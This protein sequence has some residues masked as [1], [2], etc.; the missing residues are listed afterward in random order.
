MRFAWRDILLGSGLFV[1]VVLVF[2]RATESRFINI[3]D[4][5]YVVQNPHVTHGVNVQDLRWDWGLSFY[6]SNWHPLTWLSLQLDTQ[7]FG[8]ASY[9]FHRTNV[10]LHAAN[11]VLVFLVLRIMTR[12]FWPS[13]LVAAV[14]ALHPLRVESVAWVAERKDVLSVF[15]GLLTIL[16][17]AGY[18]RHADWSRRRLVSLAW[19]GLVTLLF[20]LGLLAKPM[21]VTLPCV[22]LL[23][24]YWPLGR[25]TVAG[26]DDGQSLVAKRLGLLVLEKVPWLLLS[27]VDSIMNILA[28]QS[29]GSILSL[30][31]LSVPLRLG[32]AVRGYG[33]YLLKTIW[34]I[35][36]AAHYPHPGEHL[37][38]SQV[39]VAAVVLVGVTALVVWQWRRRPY[40]LVGWLWFA[41]VLFPVSGVM[42]T[43]LQGY[44]DRFTYFP[45][46]GLLLAAVWLLA[47]W[48]Q[49]R[50]LSVPI[51]AGAVG[52]VLVACTVL[53]FGQIGYW[54]DSLT[55]WSHCL[56]VT[57]PSAVAENHIGS[58][59]YVDA[60]RPDLA[61]PHLQAA[62]QLDPD[63]AMNHYDLALALVAL[64]RP[65]TLD[66]AAEHCQIARQ[67]VPRQPRYTKLLA[68]IEMEQGRECLRD[69]RS[70]QAKEHL[71]QAVKLDPEL[72]K[73]RY[74]LG[75]ALL[76]L[77]D[78]AGAAQQLR[79]AKER[80]MPQAE[81]DGPLK[82]AL[83]Q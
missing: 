72:A 19:Y 18:V 13:A 28:Q 56:D 64:H 29:Y 47:E 10:L 78:R 57:G 75:L 69:G 37:V 53:T 25:M 32:N 58:A 74:H 14:F 54:H 76:S 36:L 3:D 27:V 38:W 1:L 33:M 21:L 15:F 42:Q 80:G 12:A 24:D 55:L 6:A 4:F 5:T 82:Q 20:T 31:H 46:I 16:A 41:G 8:V 34:P 9:A 23:L 30:G 61:L 70:N 39:V 68:F 66:I 22:L 83:M 50:R 79:E 40:L 65:G 35:D 26:T 62:V 43:G 48:A 2:W 63:D 51:Q 71:T 60:H 59:L 49:S 52:V 77:G 67:L 81:I 73:A 7:L 11:A 17:Y 44:A 45:H